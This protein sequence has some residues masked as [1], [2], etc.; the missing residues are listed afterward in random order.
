MKF[1][2]LAGWGWGDQSDVVLCDVVV[3]VQM[4]FFRKHMTD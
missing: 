4:K 3:I 2:V 1:C